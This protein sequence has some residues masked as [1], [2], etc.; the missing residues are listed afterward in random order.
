MLVPVV[1][2]SPTKQN[3]LASTTG[4]LGLTMTKTQASIFS[5]TGYAGKWATR[6]K[7]T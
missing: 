2:D 6:R 1:P 5:N 3:E 7:E 4:S